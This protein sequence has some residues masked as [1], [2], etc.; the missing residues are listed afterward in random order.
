MHH[1]FERDGIF[2][3]KKKVPVDLVRAELYKPVIQF[4]LG[5]NTTRQQARVLAAQHAAQYETEFSQKRSELSGSTDPVPRALTDEEIERLANV[6][7]HWRLTSSDHLRE[8]AYKIDSTEA[9][10]D[11]GSTAPQASKHIVLHML[12]YAKRANAAGDV[13]R[14]SGALLQNFLKEEAKVTLSSDSRTMKRLA[15]RLLASEVRILEIILKRFDGEHI[16]A[17][18]LPEPPSPLTSSKTD[19]KICTMLDLFELWKTENRKSPSQKTIEAYLRTVKD[20]SNFCNKSAPDILRT[21]VLRWVQHAA[22]QW[23]KITVENK[24][25]HLVALFN[26]GLLHAREFGIIENPARGVMAAGKVSEPRESW[27]SENLKTVIK[28]LIDWHPKSHGPAAQWIPLLCYTTGLRLE[29]AGQLTLEDVFQEAGRCCIRVKGVIKFQQNA[30][31]TWPTQHVKNES[32]R[33]R[34]PIHNDLIE[35]G[36]L[37]YVKQR[38]LETGNDPKARLFPM[39]KRDS[40]GILTSQ[41][42]KDFGNWKRKKLGIA[43]MGQVFHSFRHGYKDFCRIAGYAGEISDVLMGHS[44]GSVSR[45]YG[46]V[47]YPFAPLIKAVDSLVFSVPV[48]I[49]IG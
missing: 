37:K 19:R 14:I 21:D 28:A 7:E 49:I 38:A 13:T 35:A 23:S 43:S 6:W 31:G 46:A 18:E 9:L 5:R 39:L 33:R 42:S 12:E 29:E 41:F 30:D 10:N 27:T 20:F 34:V 36:L 15:L 45:H 3:F 32:S 11:S 47:D 24:L 40:R 16:P 8:D 26:V 22:T 2:Y 25:I 48:P 4:S 17:A 44:D 1:I